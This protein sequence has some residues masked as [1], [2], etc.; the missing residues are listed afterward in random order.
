MSG[1]Q[2]QASKPSY[3]TKINDSTH[4]ASPISTAKNHKGIIGLHMQGLR[5]P[6]E[7]ITVKF[8][9]AP[10]IQVTRLE[11]TF[12]G[13]VLYM[14]LSKGKTINVGQHIGVLRWQPFEQ[15]G[16]MLDATRTVR[17]DM[18]TA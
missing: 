8:I 16:K 14:I 18:D 5:K 3:L 17:F 11:W 6:D 9:P 1:L 15:M 2:L 13:A 12:N 4:I 7:K 10:N